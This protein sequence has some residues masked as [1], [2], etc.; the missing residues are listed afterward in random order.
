M[1]GLH[2]SATTTSSSSSSTLAKLGEAAMRTRAKRNP[3]SILTWSEAYSPSARRRWTVCL[4][5]CTRPTTT[6][7]PSLSCADR[8]HIRLGRRILIPKHGLYAWVNETSSTHL[9]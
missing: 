5:L 7:I 4:P 6:T 2:G 3:E 1:G 9:V 8:F